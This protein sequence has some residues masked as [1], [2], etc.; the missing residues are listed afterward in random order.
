MIFTL[1]SDGTMSA[2]DAQTSIRLT[3]GRIPMIVSAKVGNSGFHV[4][5]QTD[6]LRIYKLPDDIHT[7]T[8]AEG[9]GGAVML[10]S[11]PEKPQLNWLMEGGSNDSFLSKIHYGFNDSGWIVNNKNLLS[12]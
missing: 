1:Q 2:L 12:C 8:G 4:I 11:E 9:I 6:T 10:R 5:S 3:S 7:L